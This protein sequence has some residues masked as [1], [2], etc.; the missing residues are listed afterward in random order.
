MGWP[1]VLTHFLI[2]CVTREPQTAGETLH[3]DKKKEDKTQYMANPMGNCPYFGALSLAWPDQ[4]G[5]ITF[6]EYQSTVTLDKT[7]GK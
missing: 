7:A 5:A 6:G 1:F 3:F 2:L 4:K